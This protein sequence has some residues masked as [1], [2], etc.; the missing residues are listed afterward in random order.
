MDT[1]IHTHTE[2]ERER[3]QDKVKKIL[4]IKAHL[5]LNRFRGTDGRNDHWC[6]ITIHDF[7]DCCFA[8]VGKTNNR[9]VE[10]LFTSMLA[11]IV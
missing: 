11:V 1:H 10:L 5:Q 3:A 4:N 8:T 2:R 7:L 9:E 6:V